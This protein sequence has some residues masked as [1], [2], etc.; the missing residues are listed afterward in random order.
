MATFQELKEN[1]ELTLDN[2]L[3]LGSVEMILMP[4]WFFVGIMKLVVSEAGREAAQKIYYGA[5]YEGAYNWG[6][7]QI[8]QGLSGREVMEQYLGSMT[9]RGWGRFE[10][11]DMDLEQGRGSFRFHNS[12][13]A[14]EYGS[15]EEEVC[16]WVPG[17]L[18]GAFQV[19]LDQ[20]G[21]GLKVRG[22]EEGCLVQGGEDYCR[23][24]VEPEG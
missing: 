11:M 22:R 10:I 19:I 20:K 6:K 23:F 16:L 9:H 1:L 4:R 24:V 21:S 2:R 13:V 14:L 5:G 8:E 12:A 18:A 17:A 7:V 15:R 3:M